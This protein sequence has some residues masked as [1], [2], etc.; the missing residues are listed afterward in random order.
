M[1]VQDDPDDMEDS[2]FVVATGVDVLFLQTIV[3]GIAFARLYLAKVRHVRAWS[4]FLTDH[5]LLMRTSLPPI[6]PKPR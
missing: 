3:P 5:V 1:I 4:L 2:M 6:T